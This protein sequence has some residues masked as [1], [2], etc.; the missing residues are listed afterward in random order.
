MRTVSPNMLLLLDDDAL[1]SVISKL[2]APHEDALFIAL[3]CKR[4]R[5]AI[6]RHLAPLEAAYRNKYQLLTSPTGLRTNIVGAFASVARMAF[7]YDA[8]LKDAQHVPVSVLF[9]M[10]QQLPWPFLR[11]LYFERRAC[12]QWDLVAHKEHRA[13]LAF[14]AL[15]GR[16]DVLD[17][18]FEMRSGNMLGNLL[19]VDILRDLCAGGNW[20]VAAG[21]ARADAEEWERLVRVLVRPAIIGGHRR[22]IEWLVGIIETRSRKHNIDM[23]DDKFCWF[24]PLRLQRSTHVASTCSYRGARQTWFKLI[25]DA[26]RHGHAWLFEDALA[27][28]VKVWR[29]GMEWVTSL[30]YTLL[31][32]AFAAEHCLGSMA[33]ALVSWCHMNTGVL[34]DMFRTC[35]SRTSRLFDLKDLVDAYPFRDA[36][37]P[38]LHA[39]HHFQIDGFT[40][41]IVKELTSLVFVPGD[42]AYCRW[43][44][45]EAG[46]SGNSIDWWYRD[47]GFLVRSLVTLDAKWGFYNEARDHNALSSLCRIMIRFQLQPQGDAL[48]HYE[49]QAPAFGTPNSD[50]QSVGLLQGFTEEQKL[51]YDVDRHLFSRSPLA[52]EERP[53]APN[54]IQKGVAFV[55]QRWLENELDARAD[56]VVDKEWGNSLH[57]FTHV[58]MAMLPVVDA[59]SE[60]YR[61]NGRH[62]HL[63]ALGQVVLDMFRSIFDMGTHTD[64]DREAL[65]A[66]ASLGYRR[67]L[68]SRAAFDALLE[69]HHRRFRN[70]A[71]A[72]KIGTELLAAFQRC[73]DDADAQPT[74]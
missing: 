15:H 54:R 63:Q 49:R 2:D 64:L 66:H 4:L 69:T 1:D 3:A 12:R 42:E 11:G 29:P 47:N 51:A 40:R 74:Q 70:S 72:Y 24:G 14:A 71:R 9:R 5:N 55:T 31:V 65:I 10:V 7:I 50:S 62:A 52:T 18:L 25:A 60:R 26:A 35:A 43:V 57:C 44:L 46:M 21:G 13:L 61:H 37:N 38:Y 34:R 39:Q 45:R 33:S 36:T 30:C 41:E 23:L 56:P 59:L 67:Q 48:P 73:F 27:R 22:T 6:L 19:N 17:A 16:C 68:F 58:P 8:A 28:M 53:G 20:T 32:H